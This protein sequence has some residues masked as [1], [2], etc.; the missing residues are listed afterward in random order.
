MENEVRGQDSKEWFEGELQRIAERKV[1]IERE[2]RVIQ[3]E[4]IEMRRV[5]EARQRMLALKIDEA[6][7]EGDF[8]KEASLQSELSRQKDEYKETERDRQGRE[9]S[10]NQELEELNREKGELV[11]NY[12]HKMYLELREKWY[13]KLFEVCDLH[14]CI[15]QDLSKIQKTTGVELKQHHYLKGLEITDHTLEN[16]WG[17]N[18]KLFE[19]LRGI[20]FLLG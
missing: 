12:A 14:Q 10:L 16:A 8:K 5:H 15:L 17:G 3:G 18:K 6:L 19:R 1:E 4:D 20:G 2:R 13:A 7:S 11:N 9:L